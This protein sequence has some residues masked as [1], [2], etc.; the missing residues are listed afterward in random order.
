MDIGLF[1]LDLPNGKFKIKGSTE[2]RNAPKWG[3]RTYWL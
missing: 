2:K 3:V 1:L